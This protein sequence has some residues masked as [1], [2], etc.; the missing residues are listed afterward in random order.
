MVLFPLI[1]AAVSAAFA[2]ALL[3]GYARKRRL[4]QL[5]WGVALAQYMV[6]SIA[7][8]SGIT[9]GW[10]PTLYRIYWL[11]GALLNVPWLAL[12]SIALLNR[13]ALTVVALGA[14]LVATFWAF[15]K[16]AGADVSTSIVGSEDIPR[17]AAA[18]KADPS[19]RTL[20]SLYSIPAY[21]VVVAIAIWTSRARAGVRPPASRVRANALIA[22][23]TTIVAVGSTA[24]ARLARGSAFSVTLALGVAV[25]FGGFLL[26]SRPA[27]HRVEEPGESPT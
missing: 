4:P 5:A 21:G 16:V 13:R 1:A 19:L 18:W 6:A 3:V 27:Q 8:A 15:V 9:S 20:A 25:M 24:L 22:V 12:G 11:F 14:V 10:D 7:V 26:A 23:G 17:G 2:A